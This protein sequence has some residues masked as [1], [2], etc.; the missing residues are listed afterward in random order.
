MHSL[1]KHFINVKRCHHHDNSYKGKRLLGTIVGVESMG[2]DWQT[3]C[4]IWMGS[5]WTQPL[6]RGMLWG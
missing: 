6:P 4:Y 3:R 2:T 5:L 1:G